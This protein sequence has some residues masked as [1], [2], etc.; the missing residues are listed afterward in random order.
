[1]GYPRLAAEAAARPEAYHFLS[2]G[3]RPIP[4]ESHDLGGTQY[5]TL[6]VPYQAHTTFRELRDQGII[7]QPRL[8]DESGSPEDWRMPIPIYYPPF[9]MQHNNRLPVLDRLVWRPERQTYTYETHQWGYFAQPPDRL[10]LLH[11]LF[12]DK[13]PPMLEH[14]DSLARLWRHDHSQVYLLY[15]ALL[16]SFPVLTPRLFTYLSRYPTLST[17]W[18]GLYH[19]IQE[20]LAN[21]PQTASPIHLPLLGPPGAPAPEHALP[22]PSPTPLGVAFLQVG[23]PSWHLRSEP[24][25]R[26]CWDSRD[27]SDWRNSSSPQLPTTQLGLPWRWTPTTP[28][29]TLRGLWG[30][31]A[32]VLY[33]LSHPTED[34]QVGPPREPRSLTCS[35]CGHAATEPQLLAQHVMEHHSEALRRHLHG[36]TPEQ[37]AATTMEVAGSIFQKIHRS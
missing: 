36:C 12:M 24:P 19:Y 13:F 34:A 11:H 16:G 20:S 25:L 27:P 30:T 28:G 15:C 32:G 1:M 3:P 10:A 18:P 37:W 2:G 17:P 7:L 5:G 21:D 23:V 29:C 6:L 33:R 8:M 4:R 14:L 35:L 9:P 22:L 26:Y 31:H